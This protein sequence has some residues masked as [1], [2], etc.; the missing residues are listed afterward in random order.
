MHEFS[1]LIKGNYLSAALPRAIKSV[2]FHRNISYSLVAFYL[3]LTIIPTLS[4]LGLDHSEGPIANDEFAVLIVR[5]GGVIAWQVCAVIGAVLMEREFGAAMGQRAVSSKEAASDSAKTKSNNAQS[6][7]AYLQ[8]QTK[9]MRNKNII[10]FVIYATFCLPW[11]WPYQTFGIAIVTCFLLVGMSPAGVLHKTHMQAV[12]N[13]LVME[14]TS[15][16]T[17]PS[18]LS[19]QVSVAEGE[20]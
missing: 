10:S 5:N 4:A 3:F 11:L 2:N 9:A 18:G 15:P 17:S 1:M 13:G 19:L 12:K 14:T 6:V 16:M 20:S 8:G 7:V